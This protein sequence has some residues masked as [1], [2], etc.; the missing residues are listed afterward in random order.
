MSETHLVG[1]TP[2]TLALETRKKKPIQ[3]SL[4][5]SL[6]HAG[7]AIMVED[8]KRQ[9][10]S[11]KHRDVGPCNTYNCH[12]LTFASRRCA[13]HDIDINE[14]LMDDGYHE[15][16]YAETECGDVAVYLEQGAI[17][18]SGFV[19]GRKTTMEGLLPEPL[20]LSKWGY[21]HEVIHKI[22]ECIYY[23][24]AQCKF[25]RLKV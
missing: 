21:C 15:V 6:P 10:P 5:Y 2:I 12:G 20:I 1:G 19:V 18:H 11:A 16:S 8:F 7:V 23:E 9:Y 25:F 14:I 4:N 3:N 22:H 17:T 13:V 24:N